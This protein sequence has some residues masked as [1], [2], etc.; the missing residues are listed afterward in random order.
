MS[1]GCRMLGCTLHRMIAMIALAKSIILFACFALTFGSAGDSMAQARPPQI[2]Y[3]SR[4]YLKADA[5]AANR[6]LEIISSRTP[7]L[8]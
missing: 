6:K 7:R 2:L 5:V 4:D 1:K 3:I 8:T